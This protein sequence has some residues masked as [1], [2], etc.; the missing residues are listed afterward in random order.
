MSIPDSEVLESAAVAIASGHPKVAQA[1]ADPRDGA[2]AVIWGPI[3]VEVAL[4]AIRWLAEQ[5]NR[6]TPEAL[7]RRA[8]AVRRA[9][10]WNPFTWPALAEYRRVR[11]TVASAFDRRSSLGAPPHDE[12]DV[13]AM[14]DAI[15]ARA[16]SA[17]ATTIAACMRAA[18]R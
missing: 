2:A 9:S 18:T 1:R 17:D 12:S 5:C 10:R 14:T 6:D 7:R 3:L 8:K 15:L 13:D 16:E 4:L 11:N